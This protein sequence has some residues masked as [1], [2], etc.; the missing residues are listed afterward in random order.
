V[1]L[2]HR[3]VVGLA[4]DLARA[5][6]HDLHAGVVVAARLEQRELAAAVDLEIGVRVPHAVDVADLAG[7]VED[8]LAVRTR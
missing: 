4:V 1:L 8:H 7:E 2:V 3:Q 5:G 6:E